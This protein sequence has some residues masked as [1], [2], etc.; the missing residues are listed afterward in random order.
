MKSIVVVGAQSDDSQGRIDTKLTIGE[1]RVYPLTIGVPG[2]VRG[3][4][5]ERLEDEM[6]S[7]EQRDFLQ[8]LLST[9]TAFHWISTYMRITAILL[10]LLPVAFADTA[11]WIGGE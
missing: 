11:T 3:P 4:S 6:K 7:S 8:R 5:N 1:C 10:S 9:S 2:Q